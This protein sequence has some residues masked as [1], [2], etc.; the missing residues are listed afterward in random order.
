MP[1]STALKEMRKSQSMV[2]EVRG[3]CDRPPFL[4]VAGWLFIST[5]KDLPS[6][7]LIAQASGAQCQ[8]RLLRSPNPS[9]HSVPSLWLLVHGEFLNT[10]P[11]LPWGATGAMENTG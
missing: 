7:W 6:P 11:G 3:S 1:G 9:V 2:P 10:V 8:E 4:E 5:E